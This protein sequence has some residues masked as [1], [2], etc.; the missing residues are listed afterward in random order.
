MGASGEG[1]GGREKAAHRRRTRRE[2]D[3]EDSA[4]D[5]A[6]TAQGWGP[7]EDL[8]RRDDCRAAEEPLRGALFT[9]ARRI[10]EAGRVGAGALRRPRVVIAILGNCSLLAHYL[11]LHV[12]GCRLRATDL[13][14][15]HL[16]VANCLLICSTAA[17]QAMAVLGM[18][19]F[20][21]DLGCQ[22]VSYVLRVSRGV[23]IGS[24]CLL[25][26]FQAIAISP[27]SSKWGALKRKALNYVGPLNILSWVLHS[28]VSVIYPIS[29]SVQGRNRTIT[30]K[31]DLG[32]CTILLDNT[33]IISIF[34]TFT[35]FHDVFCLGL[36]SWAS[37]SMVFTLYRHRQ[38]VKYI[39]KNNFSHRSSPEMRV[40]QRILVLMS[41]FV[42][43]YAIS[44][45][46]YMYLALF[47]NTSWWLVNMST[48]ITSCFP[49]FS[50][51]ILMSSDPR[52]PRLCRTSC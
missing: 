44:S 51:F 38:Q 27:A 33:I 6:S 36:M 48:I 10:P 13:I 19:D 41:T 21:S 20:L 47:Y 2:K 43:F 52:A 8:P 24:T 3:S 12:G 50:P 34:T 45:I 7:G 28:M 22:L 37:G 17:P 15:V 23:S 25:S 4:A 46:I 39:Y 32:Y 40:S 9:A 16:T 31:N 49:T 26:V 29:A 30:R 18:K 11:F 35:S 1:G 42:S 14:L 5:G